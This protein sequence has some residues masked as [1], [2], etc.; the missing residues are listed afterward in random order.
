MK[1]LRKSAFRCGWII[2][3]NGLL[4]LFIFSGPLRERYD[5][6][7]I[8]KSMNS[9]PPSF[10]YWSALT[11]N[12]LLPLMAVILAIGIALEIRRK[13]AA[14][15]V[16]LAPLVGWLSVIVYERAK[17]ANQATEFEMTVGKILFIYPL[18]VII[19]VELFL[20]VMAF[21]RTA[22]GRNRND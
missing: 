4:I 12:P 8:F 6:E 18:T 17:V 22:T 10:S 19:G 16:N 3:A 7:F 1:M 11:A 9:S 2:L 14:P 5:Q 15:I 21:R 20:Y 13:L